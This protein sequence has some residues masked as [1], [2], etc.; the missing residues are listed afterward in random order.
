VHGEPPSYTYRSMGSCSLP[1]SPVNILRSDANP[2]QKHVH[3]LVLAD[4]S[5]SAA[6]LFTGVN[7]PAWRIQSSSHELSTIVSLSTSGAT[8]QA[9]TPAMGKNG[10]LR[11]EW[12]TS[13][14][15]VRA[16]SRQHPPAAVL[17]GQ[18]NRLR[19][20]RYPTLHT[21]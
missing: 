7:E 18:S 19:T 1:S 16:G 2:H 20:R 21:G 13:Q 17:R 15:S 3:A 12:C 8:P 9:Q 10:I 14:W 11:M 4:A 6:G 5:Q